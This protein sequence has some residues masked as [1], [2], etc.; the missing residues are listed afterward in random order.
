M[1]VKMALDHILEFA[2]GPL[3]CGVETPDLY[4]AGPV[5]HLKMPVPPL[6]FGIHAPSHAATV[7]LEAGECKKDLFNCSSA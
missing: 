1:F 7:T 2:S 4:N 3:L 5:A 6:D